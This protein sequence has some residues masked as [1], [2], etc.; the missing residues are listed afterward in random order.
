MTTTAALERDRGQSREM[1]VWITGFPAGITR[2]QALYISRKTE[3]LSLNYSCRGEAI[4]LHILSVCLYSRLI[5]LA[6]NVHVRYYI[7]VCGL[8]GST[9]FF[10]IIL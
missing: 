2:R 3:A 8:S 4:I 10:I 6:W 5:Y 1:S 9:V 7:I